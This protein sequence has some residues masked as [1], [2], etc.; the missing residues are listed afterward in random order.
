VGVKLFSWVA[1]LALL[2]AAVAFL[3]Y[4]MEHG[5]LSAPVRMAIGFAAGIGLLAGCETRRA[6]AYKVTADSLAA[7]GVATLFSTSY[8]SAALWHLLPAGAAFA[9]MALVTAV[10]V[11]LSI[12]RDSIYMALLGLLGGFATPMLLS[13]GEDRPFGLFGYLALL[14]VGLAWV[15]YRKRWPVLTVLTLVLT[16]LYQVGWVLRFQDESKLGIGLAVFLLFPLLAFGAQL[17]ARET[18][19]GRS[20]L[21]SR[22]VSCAAI[23][24]VLYALHLAMNPVYGRH[25]GMMFGFLFLVAVGLAA[26]AVF[27][28][29]EWLHLL[30]GGAVLA[31]FAVWL[32]SSYGP[33][34]WP[35]APAFLLL[36]AALYL[37]LPWLQARLRVKRPFGDGG[38]LGVL[39]GP[40]LMFGFAALLVLEPAAGDSLV[41]FGCVLAA[42]G[43]AAAYAAQFVEG[44]VWLTAAAAALLAEAVWSVRF[45]DATRLLPALAVY[46]VFS[47]VFLGAPILARRCGRRMAGEGEGGLL[48]LLSL[49]LLFFLAAPALAATSL[50][51]LAGLLGFLVLGLLH[52]ARE[53]SRPWLPVAGMALGFALLAA[54]WHSVPGEIQPLPALGVVLGFT[55]VVLAGTLHQR[56]TRADSPLGFAG[57]PEILLGLAGL[58]F[59]LPV[60]CD[61]SLAA[62]P[63]AFLAVL[64]VMGLAM[65]AAALYLGRGALLVGCSVLTQAVLGAWVAGGAW[66]SSE[67][68]LVPWTVLVF[69]ALAWAWSAP[70]RTR[71]DGR[72]ALASGLGLVAAQAVMAG[73]RIEVGIGALAAQVA[74]TAAL[75]AG[76]LLLARRQRRQVWALVSAL[77]GG[78]LLLAWSAHLSDTREAAAL[79]LVAA[80]L[81][82]M[83][84]VH[85]LLADERDAVGRHP[86]IAAVAASAA[87]FLAARPALATLGWGGAIGALPV[88]QAALLVPHVLRTRRQPVRTESD[89]GNLALA[90]GAV[91]GFITVAIPLQLDKEWITL[92]WALLAAALAW[93]YTR[94]P[95]RGLLYWCAGLYAAV[96]ARLAL[97]PAVLEYHPRSAMPVLN[98]YLY[99]YLLAAACCFAGARLLRE[100]D[101]H[102]APGPFP[103][104]ARLLPAAGAVLLFLLLNIEIADAFS[105]GEALTFNLVHGTLAQGLSYTIGWGVY[106]ILLLV[107]GVVARSRVARV[108]AILLVTG[109][110]LKA[111]LVDLGGL[112]GLYRVASFVGLAVCLSGVAVILQRF[113]LR[114]PEEQP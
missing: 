27:R 103:G 9:L 89:L 28:G 49:G 11:V 62:P 111:F 3:K 31:V 21:F 93:L 100:R 79:L 77:S 74:V 67:A 37:G 98:W 46:G 76:L 57:S 69:A 60:A 70:G 99:T 15:A 44:H 14:N 47:L 55:L 32:A 81:Y 4:S 50:P 72:F 54:W 10:A 42:L 107:A 25:Y 34:A 5:W 64:L 63:W 92:G 51:V 105:E 41:L 59:L 113:V 22:A 84:L 106:G 39:V 58:L 94:V 68:A 38:Q 56:S 86:W 83:H 2:V 78:A 73:F 6:R 17:L 95:H 71:G 23:P 30:G 8:A 52:E 13:T 97:N 82:A 102:L 45:L 114:K 7:A 12:R 112:A 88:L 26:V 53:G 96:F 35:A 108:A 20:P 110:I 75:A 1:G 18:D 65:G 85:P 33:G 36:F 66:K 24:P 87:F 101:D 109:T 19:G 90:A 80:P 61:R 91:L 16:T 104:L 40:L 29:P 48:G 43:L